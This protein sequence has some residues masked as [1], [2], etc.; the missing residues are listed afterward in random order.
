MTQ[1][2][3]IDDNNR[4]AG[5]RT[6]MATMMEKTDVEAILVPSRLRVK[7]RIMPALVTDPS[8]LGD[9][10]PLSPAFPVNAAQQLAKLTRTPAGGRMAA[11]LRPCEVRGEPG[12]DFGE[13]RRLGRRERA[14]GGVRHV[15]VDEEVELGPHRG[16]RVG[17]P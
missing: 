8:R 1:A 10:D 5:I 4:L 7:N 14:A 12:P 17:T 16:A 2:I 11:V 13:G 9:A 6:L 15:P 3:I